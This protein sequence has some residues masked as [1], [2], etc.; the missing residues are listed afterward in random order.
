[1]LA[2]EEQI[3]REILR[4][5]R[6]EVLQQKVIAE[7][8]GVSSS[9]VHHALVVPRRAGA[10]QVGGR[11]FE[12][13]DHMKLQVIWAVF[14]NLWQDTQ[15]DVWSDLPPGKTEGLVSPFPGVRFT[16]ASA[17]KFEVGSVPS[18][19]DHVLAYV[20]GAV[21]SDIED[22]CAAH[23]TRRARRSAVRRQRDVTR[24][25]LLEPDPR[26]AEDRVPLAQVYVDLWGRSRHGG[27][28]NSR[29]A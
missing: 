11:G 26:L 22:R 21:V 17:F 14:R 8:M 23:F 5:P 18:D 12:L 9:T 29:V 24:L 2:T 3:W 6:A 13:T 7:R 10:V 1:M 27:R 19:D 4:E 25:T 28:P 20:P 15:L 16:A